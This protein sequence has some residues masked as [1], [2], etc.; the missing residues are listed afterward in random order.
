MLCVL[1]FKLIKAYVKVFYS[2][3][4]LGYSFFAPVIHLAVIKELYFLW[5]LNFGLKP[6]FWK[7]RALFPI[8][9]SGMS[10]DGVGF[11]SK[12]LGLFFSSLLLLEGMLQSDL[13]FRF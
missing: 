9:Y 13:S 6:C 3:L 8:G 10:F 11:L 12:C 7:E 4:H 2:S 5:Y 1:L